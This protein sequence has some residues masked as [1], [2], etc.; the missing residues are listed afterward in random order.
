[1][2]GKIVVIEGADGSGKKTQT[3]LLVKRA[4]K[5][6]YPTATLS[7]PQYKKVY[8]N[9][10]RAYLEGKYGSLEE[11]SPYFASMLY[12]ADRLNAKPQLVRLLKEGKNI[13]LD[14]YIESN[15]AHQAGKFSGKAR[16]EMIKWIYELELKKMKL[17]EADIVIYLDL[18]VE[19]SIR[20][21]KKQGEKEGKKRGDLHERSIKHL[22][23][24]RSTYLYMA[25]RN[26]NWK[27]VNCLDNG[28]RISREKLNEII[29][30][31]L[32]QF[33]VK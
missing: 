28:E 7:F 1:M 21:M 32:K 9:E 18:P 19:F 33:L 16:E 29:W 22:K 3:K 13:I 11:V 27:I 23:N 15:I 20:A 30:K 14:R 26:K 5:Q 8:G 17:P 6:G 31:F 25:K 12:A 2:K 10:I 4:K 24:T